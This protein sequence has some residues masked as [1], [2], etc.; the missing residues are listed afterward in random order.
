MNF[1]DL[2]FDKNGCCG[3]HKWAEFFRENGVKVQVFDNGDGSFDLV[4]F[5]GMLLLR[6]VDN[7]D[8]TEIASQLA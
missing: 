6:R 7:V 1:S 5:A 8:V 2:V 4:E 3:S